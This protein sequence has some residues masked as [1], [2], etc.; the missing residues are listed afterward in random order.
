MIVKGPDHC[1]YQIATTITTTTG[2]TTWSTFLSLYFFNIFVSLY[3]YIIA[4]NCQLAL[5]PFVVGN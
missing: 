2:T 5:Y 1:Q 4:G 3:F